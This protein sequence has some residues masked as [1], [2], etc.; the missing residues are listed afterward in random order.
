M[1]KKKMMWKLRIE[2]LDKDETMTIPYEEF[3]Y[4]TRAE[5]EKAAEEFEKEEDIIEAIVADEPEE[6]KIW[7]HEEDLQL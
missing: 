1:Y 4:K 6:R 5:A 3:Y 2:Y 7:C